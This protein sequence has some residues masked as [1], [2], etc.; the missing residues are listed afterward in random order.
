MKQSTEHI[1]PAV[2]EI[3]LRALNSN[4]KNIRKKIGKHPLIMAVVKANA[5]GHGAREVTRSI[6]KHKTA[7][8]F[9]VA[10]VEEGIILRKE[11]PTIPIHAF[12]TP[13]KNQLSLFVQYNIEPTICD[14]AVAQKLNFIAVAMKKKISVHVKID[15]GMG[16]IGILPESTVNFISQLKKLSHIDIKGIFTHFA[17]SDERDLTFAKEQLAIFRSVV[18]AIELEGIHIPL[19]HCANSGAIL[20]MPDAYFDM[21]RPGI[22]MYGYTPSLETKKTVRIK[23]VMEIKARIG[24]LKR[25]PKNTSISYSRRYF[26]KK[27]TT[28]ASVTLGYADGFSRRL[29][30][31]AFALIR[32]KKY[33]IVG[34]ICMDQI[35]ID[36][37]NDNI[38]LGDEVVVLGKSRNEN[39]SAW[40]ISKTLQTIP[41]EI[42]CGISERV[43]RKYS[44]GKS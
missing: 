37:G 20:Q 7:Q 44:Y 3:N 4:L 34:T 26:T 6:C 11:F 35:M 10:I 38:Q 14:F 17:T 8:Y 12:T 2:A 25:I 42:T 1:R 27:E 31:T 19:V 21:V 43:P 41:Y 22:M 15:T 9:G 28:I 40:D 16:R 33:P 30:N 24:F 23:P 5:Y 32:G 36:V 29:T 18:M 39:I 13:N